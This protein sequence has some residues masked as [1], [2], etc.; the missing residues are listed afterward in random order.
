MI[1]VVVVG[2]GPVGLML[3]SELRLAGVEVLVLEK[4]ERPT[5][6]SKALGITGRGEDFLAMR[7]LLERFRRRAPPAPPGIHH[8]AL[9]PLDVG[10]TAL[11]EKGVFIPQAITEEILEERALELG[12]T[13]RRG[14]TVA[15]VAQDDE[16]V[17]IEVIEAGKTERLRA[18][19]VVG[20]DGARSVV[21]HA[22]GIGFSG[23][24]P[25]SLLRLGDVNLDE[26][27]TAGPPFIPLGDGWLRVVVKEPMPLAFDPSVPMTLDELKKSIARVYG[28]AA[29]L[30]EARWLSR[31]TDASRLADRYRQGRVFLAG[32]AAHIHLPAGGPGLL[33]GFGDALNLGWK[34]AAVLRR[35]APE[36]IPR[37]LRPRTARRGLAR[38]PSHARA[39]H[40]DVARRREPRHA[41]DHDGAC[42][43]PRRRNAPPGN[44]LAARHHLRD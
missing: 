20:C 44:A 25:T 21:R 24:E 34:L 9:I 4:L 22:A 14:V 39:G 38:P 31:F 26:G 16:G 40:P 42:E 36:R 1:D 33:T 35:S 43:D 5:G 32:D 37:Q 30:R 2:A 10:K 17:T 15:G 18:H 11:A 8:F 3:A 13:I 41:S 6:L 7:G 12:T 29:P 27:A 23:M 28:L 19:Y